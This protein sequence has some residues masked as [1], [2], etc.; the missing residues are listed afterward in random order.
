LFTGSDFEPYQTLY[1]FFDNSGVDKYV[2]RSN[3]FVLTGNNLGYF[4]NTAGQESIV[5]RNMTTGINVATGVVVKTSN[6]EAFVVSVNPN[7]AIGSITN[8]NLIGSSSSTTIKVKS[9]E[10]YSGNAA[11]A[12][13][14]NII[15]RLDASG[16]AYESLYANTANL[17][18]I[19]IVSGTGAGQ[20]R[21]INAYSA[22]TRTARISSNW[23]T[24]PDANSIYTIGRPTT[25]ESGDVAG[26]FFVPASTFRVGEKKF[27]L[28][29]NST[30][31]V[32]SSST[33][34]DASFFAQG[35]LGTLQDTIIS[36]TVPTTQRVAAKS[37]QVVTTTSQTTTSRV[38]GWIDPLAQTFLVSPATYQNGVY[39]DRVRLCFETKS[40]TVPV[41]L[42]IRPTVNGYP[43]YSTIYP[44]ATVTLTPD[45]IN[46]VQDGKP[47]LA[48][49]T[50]YTEFVFS[51]PVYVQPGEHSFCLLSNCL[52]YKIYAA[53]GGNLDFRT[54]EQISP[55]PYGGLLFLS[56]NGS[57]WVPEP[58]S[59]MTFAMYR[60]EFSNSAAT[61]TFKMVTPQANT[62]YDVA[63][64]V[65]GDM[66]IPSTSVN[67]KFNSI[68]NATGGLA[69]YKS[70]TPSATY[71]MNDG[72]GRRI[73]TTAN[74]GTTIRIPWSPSGSNTGGE[75]GQAS[76][77]TDSFVVQATMATTDTAISPMIDSTRV[78]VIVRENIINNLPLSN[79]GFIVTSGGSGY[80]SGS[81][82]AVT[83]SGGNGSGA[84][85]RANV[86]AAGVIDA[87][88]LTNNGGSGYTTSPTVTI[89]SGAATVTYNG[90]DTKSG[91]NAVARYITRKVILADGFESGDL[92]VYLTAYKPSTGNIYVYAK[93]L[94]DSDPASFDDNNYQ[95][96]TQVDTNVNFVSTNANDYREMTFAPGVNNVANNSISY[97]SGTTAFKSFKTFAIKIVMVGTEPTDVPKIRDFRA[98]ATP[99]A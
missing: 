14:S 89:A 78:G 24:V 53:S 82:P 71:T 1:P 85:A 77:T 4:A 17:S 35:L 46:L 83:I 8:A 13:V 19:F 9:Y 72:S 84:T 29:N 61:A 41:T 43:S 70:I 58:K 52:D 25:N 93:L 57:T 37:E 59:A 23:T 94:S 80:S 75:L 50:K 40:Q 98:I 54:G 63:N 11:G 47:D 95:L 66:V 5:V 18:T 44:Y 20:Q 86:T 45:K 28:I 49:A 88:Y 73:L 55:V 51:S 7:T 22:A 36:A 87:I 81:P 56:Q 48:D 10:H 27:R 68:V 65:V 3:K 79:T 74:P 92:R 91:G 31:D 62:V 99:A 34:G 2:S 69:G 12:N 16:S 6:N 42:Q 32:G 64:L 26:I 60:S 15:L 97:V 38:T 21:T 39:I 67:Y 33:N 76:I 96:L 90:E 30:N